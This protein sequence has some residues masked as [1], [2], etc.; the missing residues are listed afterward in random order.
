MVKLGIVIPC[1][2]EE[3]VV[4][5]TA[6]EVLG[7]LGDLVQREVISADSFVLFVND[8]STDSTWQ[9]ITGLHSQDSRVKGLNLLSNVG[10][11]NAIM[12]GMM[13]VRERVDAVVT[14]DA[15]LQDDIT[16][17]EKMLGYYSEGCDIVYGVRESREVNGY[18]KRTTARMFYRLQRALGV[19]IVDNHADFRLMSR[20]ALDELAKYKERVLYLR[21]IVPLLGLRSA[22][23]SYRFRER[24]AGKSKYTLGKMLNLG[25]DGITGFSAT[26]IN[27]II[28]TGC[29]FLVVSFFMMLY[30]LWSFFVGRAVSGWTSIMLSMWFIGAMILLSIG[31]IGKY[32]ANIF[33][34]VKRRPLYHIDTFLD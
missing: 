30:I 29:L 24:K 17:L 5:D 8:G 7:I 34:E 32:I 11:Q 18:F 16:C 22:E 13:T 14:I 26:P 21:G 19:K 31:V 4:A 9:L 33:A 2:N 1:Y 20:R 25:V 6:A 3:A 28:G 23:V 12:A 15:D 10:Q 27:Y